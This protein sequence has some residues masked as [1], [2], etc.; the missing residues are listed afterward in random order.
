VSDRDWYHSSYVSEVR[1]AWR[2][3]GTIE[4]FIRLVDGRSMGIIQCR[5]WG[6][7][8]YSDVDRALVDL[9]VEQCARHLFPPELAR[10]LSPRLRQ[11]HGWLLGGAPAKQIAA[12]L[13][14]SLNTVNAYI[15]AVYRAE[16]A[17]S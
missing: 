11:V 7:R 17:P 5:G 8:R 13:G 1:R 6:G 3:D 14:L 10:A 2:I 12:A 9:F 4:G 16:G 15:R